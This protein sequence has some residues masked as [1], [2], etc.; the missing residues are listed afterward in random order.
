MKKLT[1]LVAALLVAAGLQAKDYV[2]TS[3]DGLITVTVSAG[4]GVSYT[5]DKG[6]V[7]LLDPSRVSMTLQDGTLFGGKDKFRVSRRSVDETFAAQNFKRATVRD[8]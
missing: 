6:S 4:D 5:V 2:V 1:L 3:P 7:R 8:H